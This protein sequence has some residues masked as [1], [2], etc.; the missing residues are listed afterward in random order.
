LRVDPESGLAC[1]R[2]LFA[3]VINFKGPGFHNT[4]Y[5]VSTR[6]PKPKRKRN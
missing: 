3:P 4:D 5:G 6:G 2:I 1:E